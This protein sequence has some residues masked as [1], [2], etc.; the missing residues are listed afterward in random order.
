R[1][2][3]R[4]RKKFRLSPPRRVFALVTLTAERQQVVRR[5]RPALAAGDDVVRLLGFPYPPPLQASN[6]KGLLLQHLGP[7]FPVAPGRT[8]AD[9]ESA[10]AGFPVGLLPVLLAVAPAVPCLKVRAAPLSAWRKRRP[11][12][13]HQNHTTHSRVRPSRLGAEPMASGASIF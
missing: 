12:A 8:A 13:L 3:R 6:T 2:P 11:A 1:P 7:G 10:P 4:A 9:A 5:V